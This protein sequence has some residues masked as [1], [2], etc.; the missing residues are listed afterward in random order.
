MRLNAALRMNVSKKGNMKI[1]NR[2]SPVAGNRGIHL[3]LKGLPPT[4]SRLL[5]FVDLC[6]FLKI[7]FILFEMEDMFPWETHPILR[8]RNAYSK[9][10]MR[11]FYARCRRKGIEVIPLVQSYGHLENVLIRPQFKKFREQKDNPQDI[12]PLKGGAREVILGM[13]RD[14]LAVFP[15]VKYFHLGGDEAWSMG[16]CPRCKSFIAKRGK[17]ALYLEQLNPLLDYLHQRSIRPILWHDMM[18]KWSMPELKRL[19]DRA[20]LMVWVYNND[21]WDMAKWS[22]AR[23]TSETVAWFQKARIPLWGA[24]AYRCGGEGAFPNLGKRAE[25]MKLWTDKYSPL[26][27]KGLV[28]TGW[29]RGSTLIVGYGPQEYA[30]KAL[31]LSAKIMWDGRYDLQGDLPKILAA[32]RRWIS[33]EIFETGESLLACLGR[34][35]NALDELDSSRGIREGGHLEQGVIK[36]TLKSFQEAM[37]EY[38]ALE[39]KFV[40]MTKDLAFAGE[41]SWWLRGQREILRDRLAGLRKHLGSSLNS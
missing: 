13:V 32:C 36:N 5:Q 1:F 34:M 18:A 35:G 10:Q 22:S 4:F 17:A 26:R 12:C 6:S 28:A 15:D 29:S 31:A 38:E 3:D 16:T 24:G 41:T 14:V 20:D 11:E 39:R 19:K 21:V 27:L 25:N 23:K 30:L 9:T 2:K 33:P 7:N 8:S 37:K 40:K